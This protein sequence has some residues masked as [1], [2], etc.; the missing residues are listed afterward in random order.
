MKKCPFRYFLTAVP[1]YHQYQFLLT[2]VAPSLMGKRNQPIFWATEKYRVL[3]RNSSLLAN[4]TAKYARRF[5]PQPPGLTRWV[6][7][8]WF[9]LSR[10]PGASATRGRK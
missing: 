2:P 1:T 3:L 6:R 10:P 7:F 8:N 4:M 9:K 5:L